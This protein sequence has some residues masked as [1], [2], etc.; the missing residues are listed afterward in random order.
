ML[1]KSSE[2]EGH[3]TCQWLSACIGRDLFLLILQLGPS[4]DL[5]QPPGWQSFSST[6]LVVLW[7]SGKGFPSLATS[8]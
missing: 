3:Y 8:V 4:N 1:A 6:H 5:F 2:V 7:Y